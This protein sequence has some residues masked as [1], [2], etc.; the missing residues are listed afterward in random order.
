MSDHS[1]ILPTS[2]MEGVPAERSPIDKTKSMTTSSVAVLF[3]NSREN[4]LPR[5]PRD[6]PAA[7]FLPPA[8]LNRDLFEEELL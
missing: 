7:A 4:A 3:V 5:R 8:E 1:S 2:V 6:F